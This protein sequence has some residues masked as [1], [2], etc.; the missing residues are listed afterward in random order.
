MKKYLSLLILGLLFL[1]SEK[2]W[3]E[4][5]DSFWQ[6]QQQKAKEPFTV[7]RKKLI[8]NRSNVKIE[9]IE[10]SNSKT[11]KTTGILAMPVKAALRS[12]P[13]VI[14][15]QHAGV[16]SCDIKGPL[17]ADKAIAFEINAHGI[18]NGKEVAFYNNLV[19]NE[20]KDYAFI[21]AD[22]PEK[23]YFK[24]MYIANLRAISFACSLPEW[25]GKNLI[26]CGYSM[27]GAQA[28]AAAALDKRVSLCVTAAPA[29]NNHLGK[30]AS[31]PQ[32]MRRPKVLRQTA[33][34]F[35][36]CSF[37]ERM[38]ADF[39]II[40][41]GQDKTC[42][43]ETIKALLNKIPE[44][45]KKEVIFLEKRNHDVY[46]PFVYKVREIVSSIKK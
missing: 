27:G 39:I 20:L 31:W 24:D 22:N 2:C 25:D 42:P 19:K 10:L 1:T 18:E 33:E 13:L 8:S 32:L 12:L 28:I 30:I 15:F 11:R 35:E 4:T 43:P 34:F 29:M 5:F 45:Q 3:A 21:G 6:K 46:A 9:E 17:Y 26:V 23:Y 7:K 40:Y 38:K 36:G 16:R 44:K 14:R 37:A 41:G